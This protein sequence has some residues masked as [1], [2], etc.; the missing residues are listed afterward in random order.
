MAEIKQPVDDPQNNSLTETIN[1]IPNSSDDN[2]SNTTS[3]GSVKEILTSPH[4]LAWSVLL[5]S[6][7][8]F[9]I[10][11]AVLAFAGYWFF[12][13]S[14]TSLNVKLVISRGVVTVIHADGN[15]QAI[16]DTADITPGST[17]Q[18]DANSQ[19][20]LTFEDDNTGNRVG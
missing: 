15:S 16:R 4:I 18:I 8:L 7:V 1:H 12:Y 13:E 14:P 10:L 11:C 3:S 17:I 20:Y 9:C 19:A 6:F 2:G 5:S